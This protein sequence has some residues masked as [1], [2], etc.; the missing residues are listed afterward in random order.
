[1]LT[2]LLADFREQGL[3]FTGA[4]VLSP[5]VTERSPQ[6][7][8]DMVRVEDCVDSSDWHVERADGE[9]YEDEAGG[10][11]LVFADVQDGGEEGWM[12]TALALGSVGSC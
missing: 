12:V 6:G 2:G 11:R 9:P 1:M 5:R 7:S 8:P 10:P 4:L 3:V